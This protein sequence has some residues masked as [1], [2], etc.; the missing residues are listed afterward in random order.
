MSFSF[1][2]EVKNMVIFGDEPTDS[3]GQEIQTTL[4]TPK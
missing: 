2:L 1:W 3:Y 4:I